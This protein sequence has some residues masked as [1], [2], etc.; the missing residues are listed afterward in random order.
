VKLSSFLEITCGVFDYGYIKMNVSRKSRSG[1]TAL[2]TSCSKIPVIAFAG[3]SITYGTIGQNTETR[4]ANTNRGVSFWIPALT[5]Q[6]L[7]TRQD[8]NF[9][10]KADTSEMLLARIGDVAA[11]DADIVVVH[12]GTNDVNYAVNAGTFTAFKSNLNAIWDALLNAGKVVIAIPPL[13]RDIA[14]TANRAMLWQMIRWVREQQWTGRRNFHVVDPG[15]LFVDPLSPTGAPRTGYTYDG[16]HP[17]G[18]GAFAVAKPIADLLNSLYPAFND[19]PMISVADVYNA[20]FNPTGNL[21]KNGILNGTQGI[22]GGSG[23][24]SFAGQIAD[25]LRA[26]VYQNG[27]TLT[28]LVVT[29]SKGTGEDGRPFQQFTLA[30]PYQGGFASLLSFRALPANFADY[31][32]GDVVVGE[33]EYEIEGRDTDQNVSGVTASLTLTMGGVSSIFQDGRE[34]SNADQMPAMA[35]KAVL[36]TPPA[37]LTALPTEIQFGAIISFRQ[38][39]AGILA[40]NSTVRFTGFSL[41]KVIP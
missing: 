8:L 34:G 6:H 26:D 18:Q 36:R 12:I 40:A 13:P 27:G 30:G 28:D 11:S 25:G 37:T 17:K 38:V 3:D 22:L 5:K 15:S 33:L 35:H 23:G 10:V 32:I 24:S 1:K 19:C 16:L 4:T 14:T 9:G 31:A 41:R 21:I 29:A 20:Q 2:G 7:R 39:G